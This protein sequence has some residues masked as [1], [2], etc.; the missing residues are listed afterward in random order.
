MVRCTCAKG[1]VVIDWLLQP[2]EMGLMQ[3]ALLASLL[4]SATCSLL[5]VFVVLRRMA[6]LSE[7]VAHTTLPGIV[8]AYFNQW[9]LLIGAIIAAVLT[10]LSIGWLGRGQRLR[11]DTAIGIDYSGM[12]AL[13]IVMISSSKN[14]KDFTHL[15]VGNVLGV[16]NQDL[17]GIAL[18]CCVVCGTLLAVGKELVLTTVDP[19]HAQTIGLSVQRMRYLLLILLALAVVTAIQAVGVVLT[20]ALMV[21]PAATATLITRRLIWVFFWSVLCSFTSSV[22]GLYISYYFEVSAGGAI[23]LSC[24]LLFGLVY[25]AHRLGLLYAWG[26]RSDQ[27]PDADSAVNE[28]TL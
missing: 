8:V 9:N 16:N 10:A 4:V 1:S 27:A 17:L 23:V 6:F 5:G 3:R 26:P 13:G 25:I 12:F 11:E 22:L 14:F 20:T 15:L 2:F 28:S 21:T 24:T 7:A 19:L 18:V